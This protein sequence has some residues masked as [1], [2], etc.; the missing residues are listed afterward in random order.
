MLGGD[1]A[2][3]FFVVGGTAS[4]VIGYLTDRVRS[5]VRL[6]A[7]VVW[8]GECGSLL[9]FWVTE[10]WQFYRPP[11]PTPFFDRIEGGRVY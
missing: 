4:L 1:I 7:Y 10:Y 5:R 3:A 6:F 9:T 11:Q 2:V 8:A